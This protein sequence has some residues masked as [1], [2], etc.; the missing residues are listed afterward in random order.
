MSEW[1]LRW[2]LDRLRHGHRGSTRHTWHPIEDKQRIPIAL[3]C[4]CG[5]YKTLVMVVHTAKAVKR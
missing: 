5:D 4:P 2:L 3:V 1:L